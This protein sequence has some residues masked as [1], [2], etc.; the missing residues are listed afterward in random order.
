M[1]CLLLLV[2]E[3][4]DVF[5]A[6]RLCWVGA[7]R[8][9]VLALCGLFGALAVLIGLAAGAAPILFCVSAL[10]LSVATALSMHRR[11]AEALAA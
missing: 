4:D 2:D 8:N 7:R 1:E 3:I 10:V 9:V 5:G 6:L 11:A